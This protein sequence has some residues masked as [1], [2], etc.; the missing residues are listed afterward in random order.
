MSLYHRLRFPCNTCL[1]I[2]NTHF[3]INMVASNTKPLCDTGN[4]LTNPEMIPNTISDLYIIKKE[5]LA[6]LLLIEITK[7]VSQNT[8]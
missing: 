6:V 8:P 2:K 5:S 7:S 1:I 3:G 4:V